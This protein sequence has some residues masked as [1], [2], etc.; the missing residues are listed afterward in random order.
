MKIEYCD[1]FTRQ[2]QEWCHQIPNGYVRCTNYHA[3]AICELADRI[4]VNRARETKHLPLFYWRDALP[5]TKAKR[6]ENW[7]RMPV[8]LS[9]ECM[10]RLK[11]EKNL[12]NQIMVADGGPGCFKNNVAGEIDGYLLCDKSKRITVTR[13]ECFGIPNE[14]AVARYDEYFFLGL[15][16]LVN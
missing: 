3:C 6:G 2:T 7:Y 12:I 5:Q 8:I 1:A 16:R 10:D 9:P 11:L 14:R 15:S 13:M 4:R